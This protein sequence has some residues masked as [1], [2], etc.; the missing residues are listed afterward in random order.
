[1]D[2]NQ[3]IET[4]K[5]EI[6]KQFNVIEISI[7]SSNLNKGIW[8]INTSFI[9]NNEQKFYSVNVN[10]DS[11]SIEDVYETRFSSGDVG[12]AP[13][14]IT[15]AFVFSIL[16]VLGYAILFIIYSVTAISV[17]SV[18]SSTSSISSTP[19]FSGLIIILIVF[20]LIFFL[21]DI[22]ILI[23]IM[24]IRKLIDNGDYN[25]AYDKNSV[26]FG[27][28]ALIFGGIITGILLLVA[29]DGL[30]KASN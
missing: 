4:A 2:I 20:F 1:M 9:L 10:N 6:Q 17:V 22:Y 8:H 14:L 7:K 19:A 30:N 3:A 24:K 13:T 28:L 11:G 12:S 27:I 5:L 26:A 16:A 18:T 21:I 15:I 25:S 23:R 29:R